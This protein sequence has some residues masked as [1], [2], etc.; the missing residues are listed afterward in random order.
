MPSVPF[1]FEYQREFDLAVESALRGSRTPKEAL[2]IAAANITKIIQR[3]RSED[4]D[5]N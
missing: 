1:I 2:D 5:D 3:Q 4:R